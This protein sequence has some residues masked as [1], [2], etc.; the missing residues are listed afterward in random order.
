MTLELFAAGAMLTGLV[1]YALTG[2]ADFGGGILDLVARG[3]RRGAQRQAIEGALAPVWEANHVWLIFVVVV[4][5]TAFPPAFARIGIDLHIPLTVLLFAIVL[6]G[7]A[8]VFRQYGAPHARERWGHVFAYSSLVASFFLG[9]VLG[10]LTT[11]MWLGVF[12][13]AVGGMTIC[14]FAFLAATYLCV[15]VTDVDVREDFRR[16]AIVAGIAFLVAAVAAAVVARWRAPLFAADLFGSSGMVA[17]LVTGGITYGLTLGCVARRRYRAARTFAITTI[18]L[19]IAGWAF[20]QSPM[21]VAPDVTIADAAAPR[22]TLAA[23]VP[24]LLI[25]SLVLLPSLWW[26]MRVFKRVER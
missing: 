7:S 22:V 20:A 18:G 12:A 14:A 2:G 4:L 24:V 1:V 5:F 8:F 21:L 15:E 10:A 6:R 26:L 11:G 13:I 19:V 9:V 16:R 17:L 3:P 25:G 23:L